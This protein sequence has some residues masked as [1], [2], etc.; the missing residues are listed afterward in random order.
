MGDEMNKANGLASAFVVAANQLDALDPN[1]KI[2]SALMPAIQLVDYFL[3]CTPENCNV[4]HAVMNEVREGYDRDHERR[5]AEANSLWDKLFK[6]IFRIPNVRFELPRISEVLLA[7]AQNCGIEYHRL[8]E[9]KWLRRSL[10]ALSIEN[11]HMDFRDSYSFMAGLCIEARRNGVDPT[12]HF[13]FVGDR[14]IK[15]VVDG[16][17]SPALQIRNF[18]STACYREAMNEPNFYTNLLLGIPIDVSSL[19][20]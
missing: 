14:S 5:C 11:L 20:K 2:G 16:G 15:T 9:I 19:R 7:F 18:Q 1:G 12:E 6:L 4:I 17:P 8:G 13:Q 3:D 10:A